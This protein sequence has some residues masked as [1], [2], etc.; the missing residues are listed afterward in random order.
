MENLIEN[1]AEETLDKVEVK[2]LSFFCANEQDDT[3]HTVDIDHNGEVVL[4]CGCGRFIKLPADTTP[5]S[6]QAYVVAHR[7]ANMGQVTQE[8]VDSKKA[9]LLNALVPKE[10]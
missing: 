2:T 1:P 6:L 5:E 7:E 3:D 4:S 10:D 8:E 9:E